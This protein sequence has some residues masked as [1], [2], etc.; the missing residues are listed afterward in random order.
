[1]RRQTEK[2][3]WLGCVLLLGMSVEARKQDKAIF[4]ANKR[5][6]DQ[7]LRV[8]NETEDPC[9][10]FEDYAKGKYGKSYSLYSY[11]SFRLAVLEKMDP[12]FLALFEQLKCRNFEKGSLGEKALRFYNACEMAMEKEPDLNYAS[13]VQPDVD[14]TWPHGNQWPRE[15]F[16]WL[17]TLGRLRRYGVDLLF[18]MNLEL[19]HQEA[20]KYM[21]SL[22]SHDFVIYEYYTVWGDVDW[23]VSR[24]FN[25]S[26][27]E[28]LLRDMNQLRMDII[29]ILGKG[30]FVRSR[31]T[32]QQLDSEGFPIRKYL[33]IVFGRSFAPNFVVLVDYLEYLVK[34]NQIMNS[35]G[36][37]TVATYLMQIFDNFMRS[38]H[39]IETYREY[40]FVCARLVKNS[41]KSVSYLLYE[42]HFLGQQKV[43]EYD[44]Q[45][46]LSSVTVS[47]GNVPKSIGYRR[48][49]T[50][51]Y[52]NIN[53]KDD[54]DFATI[55][56]RVLEMETHLKLQK[57]ENLELTEPYP[58]YEDDAILV[59]N[60]T[61]IVL[62]FPLMEEPF[63]TT[64]GHDVFKVSVHGFLIAKQVL[65]ALFPYPKLPSSSGCQKYNEL[66]GIFD[67]L[68]K[69]E[70]H[71][72][73]I[74]PRECE[75]TNWRDII[76]VLL[77]LVQDAYFSEG[78]G[79]DQT[80]PSFIDKPL[81]Q[82][83]YL[84]FA[85][86]QLSSMFYYTY[87]PMFRPFNPLRYLPTFVEAFN[88]STAL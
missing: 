85:Q 43:K 33:E 27:A 30:R 63:F 11:F 58:G 40:D 82:L 49:L 66:V 64:R 77:N 20:S 41:M 54:D 76:I 59:G 16:N 9:G 5:I 37:E 83:F 4:S 17:V 78:S 42:E 81:K 24:G 86:N 50:D 2:I 48:Y 28:F 26:R 62:P 21:I 10:N 72:G 61:S 79:F 38:S 51:S 29:N 19:D 88:C 6:M 25:R 36:Q 87:N 80:Q 18:R 73:C 3:I 69:Y 60:G 57:L 31:M 65:S 34:L 35:Y 68:A 84:H 22:G 75:M 23:L 55:H 12:K 39:R 8:M 45:K 52:A 56:L 53:L 46:I 13:L 74:S 44:E 47:V 14:L 15:K 71:S 7:T 1:M 32:I 67:D 70:D